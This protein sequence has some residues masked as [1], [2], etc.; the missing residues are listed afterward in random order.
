M[1]DDNPL[2][3]LKSL[4]SGYI[5]PIKSKVRLTT[6]II[7]IHD[8]NMI[9]AAFRQKIVENFHIFCLVIDEKTRAPWGS[10]LYSLLRLCPS[11]TL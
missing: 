4:K 8:R 10:T 3:L 11:W 2:L 5:N 1:N 7:N 6:L 9:Q